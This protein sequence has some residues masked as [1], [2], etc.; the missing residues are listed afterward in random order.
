M[1]APAG[2]DVGD[3]P[4]VIKARLLVD[5]VER[6]TAA[7]YRQAEAERA[8]REA[9]ARQDRIE[10]AL[11]DVADRVEILA[12]RPAP[13]AVPEPPPASAAAIAPGGWHDRHTTLV[14]LRGTA[15]YAE[16]LRAAADG[17]SLTQLVRDAVAEWAERRG[18]PSPP[19]I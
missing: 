10:Q 8:L 3:D 2:F 14:H 7:E 9:A 13:A 18:L 11:G 16:W 12:S 4:R 1:D 17:R 15:A 5:L 6:Q 19:R